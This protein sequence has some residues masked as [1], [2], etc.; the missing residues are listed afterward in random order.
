MKTT[1]FPGRSNLAK[2]IIQRCSYLILHCF[3]LFVMKSTTNELRG[4]HDNG[5]ILMVDEVSFANKDNL[6]QN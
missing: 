3:Q 2:K 1:I 6:I 5:N 4:N